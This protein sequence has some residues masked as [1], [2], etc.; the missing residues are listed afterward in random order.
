MRIF[1]SDCIFLGGI[2]GRIP[3]AVP[4]DGNC[5]FNALSVAHVG[6][7]SLATELRVRTCIEMVANKHEYLKKHKQIRINLVSPDYSEAMRECAVNGR[8]SSAWTISAA[9]TVLKTRIVSVYPPVNGLLDKT[10]PILH[11]TFAP[12]KDESPRARIVIMWSS[13]PLPS[14]GLMWTPNHFVPLLATKKSVP[15]DLVHSPTKQTYAAV[16]DRHAERTSTPKKHVSEFLFHPFH[17]C[18]S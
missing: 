18:I 7:V 8:F 10:I 14:S 9:S 1:R 13:V 3:A 6:N 15:F 17:Y 16:T 2:N 11:S 12:T 4:A 5:L